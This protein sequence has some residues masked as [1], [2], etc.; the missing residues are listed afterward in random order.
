VLRAFGAT[1]REHPEV[2]RLAALWDACAKA[3]LRERL[4]T[5]VA[6]WSWIR[7]A[8]EHPPLP[9]G[10]DP[11]AL[12]SF[13]PL[14]RRQHV[15]LRLQEQS[16]ELNARLNGVVAGILEE[17][18][19]LAL[20][21]ETGL[22]SDRGLTA[23]FSE[24]FWRHLLPTPR[25]DSDLSKLLIRIYPTHEEAERFATMP[26]EIFQRLVDAFA[27]A[28]GSAHWQPIVHSL[29]EAFR[30][31]GVR[32]QAL[33]LSEKLRAR[34]SPLPLLESPFF[35][36]ARTTESLEQ[37][38]EAGKTLQWPWNAGVRHLGPSVRK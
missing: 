37:C 13:P 34:S 10:D 29:W 28:D 8:D 26:P 15:V 6:L 21:A 14:F 17:T 18:S 7:V 23:E 27:P 35:Q 32:I 9:D 3:T 30:L 31:L 20:F 12:N 1:Y 38:A 5:V 36:L 2:L 19:S 4:E 24:R 33:G 25:E 22:P 11:A 16:P